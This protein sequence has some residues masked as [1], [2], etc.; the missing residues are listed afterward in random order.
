MNEPVIAVRDLRRRL[1]S[2][3]LEIPQVTLEPGCV[4]RRRDLTRWRVER[5]SRTSQRWSG[6][7][8]TR[9][10]FPRT[11]PV[12]SKSPITS[13]GILESGRLIEHDDRE[14]LAERRRKVSGAVF[15]P[16]ADCGALLTAFNRDGESFAGVTN[17][18]SPSW[19]Q[20]AQM[21]GLRIDTSA[22]LTLDEILACSTGHGGMGSRTEEV[23]GPLLG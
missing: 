12:T 7:D 16:G 20:Q 8:I 15:G 19:Q 18:Y 9:R 17:T 10:S 3:T 1:G 6:T 11:S 21:R 14:Q 4:N 13:G 22:R 23:S 2:F 5:S